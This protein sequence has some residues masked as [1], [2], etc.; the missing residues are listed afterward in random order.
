VNII[1]LTNLDVTSAIALV[2]Q[3][4]DAMPFVV[5]PEVIEAI[6]ATTNRHPYLMQ[7]LC[8]RLCVDDGR[9]RPTL[10][11]PTEADLE[12]DQILTG[13]LRIDFKHVTALERRLLLTVAQSSAADAAE[14]AAAMP[15]V[16]PARVRTFLW[17]L[18]RLGYLRSYRGLWYVGNQFLS[19]WLGREWERLGDLEEANLA[20]DGLEMMLQAG[21]ERA[22]LNCHFEIENAALD[23]AA[24][25]QLAAQKSQAPRPEITQEMDRLQRLLDNARNDLHRNFR[26]DPTG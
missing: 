24:L 4:Q 11:P 22:R 20:D 5:A 19:R 14:L 21:Q 13:Y 6:L 2:E 16:H 10:R 18:E 7:F 17:G 25:R 12:P 1:H 3:R 26:L 9:A 8:Q 15:D 23:L